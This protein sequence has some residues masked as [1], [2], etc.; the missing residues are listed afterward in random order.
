MIA[1][2]WAVWPW[3][4]VS[5]LPTAEHQKVTQ[6][7]CSE[8]RWEICKSDMHMRSVAGLKAVITTA[9]HRGG[10]VCV[11]YKWA[12]V[13]VCV[14]AAVINSPGGQRFQRPDTTYRAKLNNLDAFAVEK[15]NKHVLFCSAVPQINTSEILYFNLHHVPYFTVYYSGCY[16]APPSEQKLAKQQTLNSISSLHQFLVFSL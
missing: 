16:L 5:V 6:L 4:S 13:C 3:A 7:P 2:V 1:N 10:M 12:C 8:G 11:G 9:A 14:F 15:L